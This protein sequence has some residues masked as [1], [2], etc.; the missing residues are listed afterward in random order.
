MLI[1][2]PLLVIWDTREELH[3]LS[4]ALHQTRESKNCSSSAS[5][6]SP[7]SKAV[8]GLG[9][10]LV[11]DLFPLVW[12]STAGWVDRRPISDL[13]EPAG[14]RSTIN[15]RG[16]RER[17]KRAIPSQARSGSGPAW[18]VGFE[19]TSG[20]PRTCPTVRAPFHHMSVVMWWFR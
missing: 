14:G 13:D 2:K 19:A 11:K 18:E 15:Q 4:S 17:R 1:H 6:I 5:E 10:G 16:V 3:L 20:R 7:S 8:F 9:F 12:R